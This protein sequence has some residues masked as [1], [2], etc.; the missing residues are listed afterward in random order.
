MGEE[1]SCEPRTTGRPGGR[2]DPDRR[3]RG[4][5]RPDVER[6]ECH[7]PGR[8]HRARAAG[9]ERRRGGSGAAAR[10]GGAA[11]R[12]HHRALDHPQAVERADGQDPQ[13]HQGAAV[14]PLLLRR[15]RQPQQDAGVPGRGRAHRQPVHRLPVR[16]LPAHRRER[17]RLQ[18]T[19]RP[20]GHLV[21]RLRRRRGRGRPAGERP[22]Q[23][24]RPGPRGRHP[25]QRAL[26][27]ARRELVHRRV[28]QRARPVLQLVRR[29]PGGQRHRR[30][31][32][33]QG[34]VRAR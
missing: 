10:G 20:A 14:H 6:D 8:H 25:L 29:L 22:E 27:R 3:H 7:R 17:R 34:A 33:A 21:D 19:R 23:L 15:R 24:L 26:L 2:R 30:R 11:G 9:R 1:C 5:H 18:R 28:E 16:D 32:G 13:G 4:P 12:H 31:P